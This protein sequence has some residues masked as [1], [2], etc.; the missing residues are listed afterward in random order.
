MK[1]VLIF[2]STLLP[3]SLMAQGNF[4]SMLNTSVTE[5]SVRYNKNDIKAFKISNSSVSI[6]TSDKAL[7]VFKCHSHGDHAH[8]EEAQN[9]T[10]QA[11]LPMVEFDDLKSGFSK[12]LSQVEKSLK[13]K[14]SNYT[15]D[16]VKTWA[17]EEVDHGTSEVDVWNKIVYTD[18][19]KKKQIYSQCHRHDEHGEISCHFKTKAENEPSL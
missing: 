17:S 2:I 15:I 1:N 5:L 13:S 14:G 12:A 18:N 9:G 19:S 3:L 4:N 6:L 7:T 16:L 8:C 11:R 10:S